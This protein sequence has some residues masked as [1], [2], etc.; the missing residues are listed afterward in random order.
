MSDP[1]PG[2]REPAPSTAQAPATR[3]PTPAEALATPWP[4]PSPPGA[5]SGPVLSEKLG[6]YRIVR[7]LGRGGMGSVYLAHDTQLDRQVA[8]KVPHFAADQGEALER[9]YREARTAGRLQHPNI[10]PVFD[11]GEAD[12]VHYLSMAFI[13][14]EPLSARTREYA[15]RPPREAAALVRTLALALEEAHRQGVIHRDLKPSNVMMNRRGEPVVMDFGLAR[16]VQAA[17]A[18]QTHQGTILGTP[19]Y[20]APEQARGDV[21][22]MGPGCDVYSLGVI[23]YELLV[24]RVPFDGPTLDVLVQQVR[25]EPPPL[26]HLRPDLD[27][28]VEAICRKAMAKEPS[29]RFL[30]MAELAQALDDYLKGKDSPSSPPFLAGGDPVAQAAAETLLLLRTWGWEAG[31]EKVRPLLGGQPA[32]GRDPRLGLLLRWVQGEPEVRAEARRQFQGVRQGEALAGWALLGEAYT[33]NRNHNFGRAEGL[34]REAAAEGDAQD[35]ILQASI[36]HQRGFW[37]Y[38]AGK[39]GEA[40]SALHQALDLCGREHFLTA[41]VLSTLGLVYANKNNFHAAREFFEQAVACQ[42]RFR[43][44]RAVAGT[45][46]QLGDLYLDWG[47][48]DRAEEVFQESLRLAFGA[49]D[50]RGEASSF[51]YLG[52]VELACGEREAGG[53]RKAAARKHLAKAAEWLDA[54]IQAHKE[55]PG[56]GSNAGCH[57]DYA[58]VCLAGEDLAGAEW[59]ARQAEQL[60]READHPDGL[61]RVRQVLGILARK[62]GNFPESLRLL[63]EA[64]AHFDR[65]ADYSE[66]TRTMLEIA[67][68]LATSGGQSQLVTSTFLDALRRAEACRRTELV[69]VA[70]EELRAVNEESYAQHVFDRVRGR[71]ATMDTSSLM[72]GGSEVVTALVL[73]LRDFLPFCQGMEP[74]EVMQT[75]NQMMADLGEVL[76]RHEAHVT[77]YLGGGFLALVRGPGHAQRAVEAALGLAAVM[78]EFNRPRA[79]LGLPQLAAGI[80]VATGTVFLGNIGTYRKMDFTAVGNA[81]NLAS[82]LIR[83]AEGRLPCLARETRELVGDRFEYAAGNPRTLDLPGLGRREVWDLVGR[84]R[85]LSGASR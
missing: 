67:R 19:A 57:R 85:G 23:L 51:H 61:A 30:S 22:A 7:L 54:S 52:R 73:N 74:E 55:S 27:P 17:A 2:P 48:L 47:Y 59:H 81:V 1:T 37:L 50:A 70:E 60:N 79:V 3:M 76:E 4:V 16:E 41:R 82:R 63:R 44:D 66:S 25:D 83:Q 53:G 64:L 68:T 26:G 62:Q 40:L 24:G 71:G 21:T 43:D 33:H 32:E 72:D 42:Q 5:G 11:V 14:G 29:R 49:Q 77:A 20:M 80:G 56:G 46:R 45:L 58:L 8:L 38:H 9:F 10:C 13:D 35:H 28:H 12:G 18:V 36:A 84:R 78:E 15:R 31:V 6:R 65:T 34:L 75:L 69:R 39:L